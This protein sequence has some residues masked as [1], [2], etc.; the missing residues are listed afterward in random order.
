MKKVSGF[1]SLIL[2]VFALIQVS[3]S[4]NPALLEA[5]GVQAGN[6]AQARLVTQLLAPGSQVTPAFLAECSA[7]FGA[8]STVLKLAQRVQQG[9]SLASLTAFAEKH[10]TLVSTAVASLNSIAPSASVEAQLSTFA[11]QSSR[12]GNASGALPAARPAATTA[13]VLTGEALVASVMK[14][15]GAPT[16]RIVGAGLT[17]AD[18]A[19]TNPALAAA[20]VAEIKSAKA[21]GPSGATRLATVGYLSKVA[22]TACTAGDGACTLLA[23]SVVASFTANVSTHAEVD[24]PVATTFAAGVLTQGGI[25]PATLHTQGM[26]GYVNGATKVSSANEL[27]QCLLGLK[28]TQNQLSFATLAL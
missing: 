16:N 10:P 23:N 24:L 6:Q 19:T 1:N 4:A 15:A 8:Q 5:L 17:F 18:L 7:A 2:G 28:A 21:A 9:E 25:V 3:A 12:L 11:A 27:G 14:Q 20:A 26:Q 13:K 22:K